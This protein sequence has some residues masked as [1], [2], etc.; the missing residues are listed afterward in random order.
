VLLKDFGFTETPT[1]IKGMLTHIKKVTVITTSEVSTSHI[2]FFRG[3]AIVNFLIKGTL[4]ESGMQ[5]TRWLNLDKTT[6]RTD[7][8]RKAFIE[9]ATIMISKTK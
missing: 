9:K 3:N 5:N 1:G 6:S 7:Q 4:L 2:R 8:A